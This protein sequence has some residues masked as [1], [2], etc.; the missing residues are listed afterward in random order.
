MALNCDPPIYA[1]PIGKITGTHYY[2]QQK[3]ES[4]NNYTEKEKKPYSTLASISAFDNTDLCPQLISL[5]LCKFLVT[6]L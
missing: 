1:S 3:K 6:F 5:L 2:I 4:F